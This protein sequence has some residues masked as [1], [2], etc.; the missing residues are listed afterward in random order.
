VAYW[1]NGDNPI[2]NGSPV[3]PDTYYTGSVGYGPGSNGLTIKPTSTAA[4]VRPS[5]LV[6]IAD[7]VYAG[8]QRDNRMGTANCRIGFRHPGSGGGTRGESS[9]NATFADGHVANI[10]GNR[11]PRALGGT[12]D[13][14]EVRA[15]NLN[16]QPTVYAN[17]EKALAP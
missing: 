10:E 4:F 1:I 11:F 5:T 12:N 14:A 3:V 17:P 6:A 13:P 16:G 8:R 9:A 15:E 2:G 7:G